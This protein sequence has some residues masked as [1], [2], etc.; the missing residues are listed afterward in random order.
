MSKDKDEDFAI[1]IIKIAIIGLIFIFVYHECIKP[2]KDTSTA[3][4][5][6]KIEDQ[7]KTAENE[8]MRRE[9]QFI[10]FKDA[11]L[12]VDKKLKSREITDKEGHM[13]KLKLIRGMIGK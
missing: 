11:L 1:R 3:K 8:N 4:A 2:E 5:Q 9:K 6:Q 13:E 12:K 10:V 7:K